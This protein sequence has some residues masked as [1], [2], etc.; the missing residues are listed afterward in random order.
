MP[1]LPDDAARELTERFGTTPE[2]AVLFTSS[3]GATRYFTAC[4][5]ACRDARVRGI[6]ENLFVAEIFEHL[7][8]DGEETPISPD[9]LAGAAELFADGRIVSGSAK[10]LV[11]ILAEEGALSREDAYRT[12]ERENIMKIEDA[13]VL[14]RYAEAAAAAL[15]KAVLDYRRGKTAAV[16]QLVGHVMRAT[17]G[18]ADPILTEK[19]LGEILENVN[20]M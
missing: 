8:P 9:A 10:K 7:G 14:R 13:E 4:A 5:V 15:P 20:D 16:K 18:R 17:S 1:P 12:A 19:L 6:M 11:R 3:V 2:N